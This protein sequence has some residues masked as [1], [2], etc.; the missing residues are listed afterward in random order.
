M[1]E[2]HCRSVFSKWEKGSQGSL[3]D[4]TALSSLSHILHICQVFPEPSPS[5]RGWFQLPTG[6]DS[7]QS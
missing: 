7:P 1:E 2:F 6:A 3:T 5:F 4:S